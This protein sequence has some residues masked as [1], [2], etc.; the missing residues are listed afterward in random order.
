MRIKTTSLLLSIVPVVSVQISDGGAIPTAG[1]KY[2]LTCSV[3]GDENLNPTI[4]YQWTKNNGTQTQVGTKSNTL[5][6][7][8]LRLSDAGKYSCW[9]TVSSLYATINATSKLFGIQIPGG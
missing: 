5:V 6:F 1:Q 4:T 9:A 7:L 3:S 8:S 2:I